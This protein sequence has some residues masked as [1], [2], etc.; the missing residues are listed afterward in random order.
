MVY[1]AVVIVALNIVHGNTVDQVLGVED[2]IQTD[3]HNKEGE[4]EE[5]LALVQPQKL[6]RDH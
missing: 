5:D 1:G 4:V 3:Y 2:N 6:D